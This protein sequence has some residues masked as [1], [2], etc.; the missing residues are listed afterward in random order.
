MTLKIF[1]IFL[2]IF[3]LFH[4]IFCINKNITTKKQIIKLEEE[5]ILKYKFEPSLLELKNNDNEYIDKTEDEININ[6]DCFEVD[7]DN[8]GVKDIV[9][10]SID[11]SLAFNTFLYFRFYKKSGNKYIL[12]KEISIENI[13]KQQEYEYLSLETKYCNDNIYPDFLIRNTCAGSGG[14][15]IL[16]IV[17][18]NGNSFITATQI[19]TNKC[20]YF[21]DINND[22]LTEIIKEDY[23]DINTEIFPPGGPLL[24][25]D[26][27]VY[28][29]G[30]INISNEKFPSFY[31]K[32][33]DETKLLLNEIQTN[34]TDKINISYK[35]YYEEGYNKIINKTKDILKK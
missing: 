9:V 22:G 12:F 1:Y 33:Q 27:Y 24:W 8:D 4:S 17:E 19:E 34:E 28:S 13:F 20:F 6:Y 7:F 11:N 14:G 2:I 25:K 31:K 23:L 21:E 18:W 3:L 5:Q 16:N 35:K 29:S 30:T 15:E 10:F 26:V 32:I